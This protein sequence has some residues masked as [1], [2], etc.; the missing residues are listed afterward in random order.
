MII[1]VIVIIVL[2]VSL[3]M[4]TIHN[5]G[6]LVVNLKPNQ[7][8][9]LPP[10]DTKSSPRDRLRGATLLP[11]HV[12]AYVDLH[13][14]GSGNPEWTAGDVTDVVDRY[15]KAADFGA[16]TSIHHVTTICPCCQDRNQ[17]N[18]KQRLRYHLAELQQTSPVSS[19]S[20]HEENIQTPEIGIY[21]SESPDL[22]LRGSTSRER[23]TDDQTVVG[24]SDP[25]TIHVINPEI[26]VNYPYP[27]VKDKP[28]ISSEHVDT[29]ID[30]SSKFNHAMKR[31]NKTI[32]HMT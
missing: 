18:I 15:L 25:D 10:T 7:Y 14:R 2:Q 5:E 30:A 16:N 13:V 21:R 24:L 23:S 6:S 11:V 29:I 17:E 8:K 12:P 28:V 9:V 4:A 20:V 31:L 19:E 22:T 3:S 32:D 1:I 26:Y 27:D